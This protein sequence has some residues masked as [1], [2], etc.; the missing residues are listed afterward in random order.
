MFMGYAAP[1]CAL[2]GTLACFP[3]ALMRAST[4]QGLSWTLIWDALVDGSRNTL[5]VALACACA[6][7]VIGSITLTGLG[8]TFTNVVVNLAHNS[9]EIGRASCRERVCQYV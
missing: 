9:L 2:A 8:I 3:V 5:A 6:G 7:L 4:R 1:L